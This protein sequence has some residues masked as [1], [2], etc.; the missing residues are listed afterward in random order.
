MIF[1][2]C[3]MGLTPQVSYEGH[4][5]PCC[6]FPYDDQIKY[7]DGTKRSN[8]FRN[9]EFHIDN[10]TVIDII[11]SPEW[12]EIT[13]D[14]IFDGPSICY[15][16]CSNFLSDPNFNS[17]SNSR[18]P[19]ITS[20]LSKKYFFESTSNDPD[21]FLDKLVEPKDIRSVGFELTSR[22]TLK[23]PYCIRTMQ[24]GTGKYYK[25]DLDLESVNRS[26]ESCNWNRV[27]DCN[28]YGDSI[29]YPK[30]HEFLDVIKY[31]NVNRYELHTAATGRG[32]DWW[33]KTIEKF[34]DLQ[35]HDTNVRIVFGID[36][37]KDTSNLHRIGQNFDEIFY[38]MESSQKRGIHEV[39]WQ[40][41]PFRHNEQQIEEV[42]EVA[43]SIGV[44]LKFTLSNRFGED[45]PMRPTD[46]NLYS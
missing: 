2:K 1:P 21:E 41:I 4:V 11:S 3:R 35:S 22:C 12:N 13:R 23:C 46:S 34:L 27:N 24:K 33:D 20:N 44:E 25:G 38:A 8:P 36:G 39:V 17:T 7:P 16:N 29:F 28:A 45:D 5:Y 26:L 19:K 32:Y 43:K 9:D 37:L 6:W 40:F 42:K 31:N 14:F 30:Y 15:K 18:T 10:N